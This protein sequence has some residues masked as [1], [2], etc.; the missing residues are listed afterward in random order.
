MGGTWDGF[1]TTGAAAFAA[2]NVAIR[3]ETWPAVWPPTSFSPWPPQVRRL[4][5]KRDTIIVA[6]ESRLY[7]VH[8][9]GN[10]VSEGS[11]CAHGPLGAAIAISDV[12]L[13]MGALL[14]AV[15]EGAI[16]FRRRRQN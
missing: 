1:V 15:A 11:G 7:N 12:V 2:K 13:A 3:A 10:S 8:R 6:K 4:A 16:L 14:K 5:V 9:R